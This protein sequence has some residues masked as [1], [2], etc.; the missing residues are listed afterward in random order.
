MFKKILCGL[1]ALCCAPAIFGAPTGATTPAG[2]LDNY[3]EA[4]TLAKKVNRP[5]LMLI[6]GSDWCP[7]CIALKTGV[8]PTNEFKDLAD[9]RLVL[10]FVDLPQKTRLN[11]E[12]TEQNRSLAGRFKLR[13]V[14]TTVIL[15]PDGR[16]LG[17]I[18][19][20]PDDYVGE[21]KKI[22]PAK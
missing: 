22:I 6:T 16:E 17:R 19:G 2:W 5:V 15:A 12:L 18:V 1:C 9:A 10:L 14:P 3:G 8:L 13:G 11:A 4:L 21:L 7:A 20:V